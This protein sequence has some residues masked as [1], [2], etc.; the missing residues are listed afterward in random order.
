MKTW[1]L[2]SQNSYAAIYEPEKNFHSLKLV[3]RFEHPEG[4]LKEKELTTDSPGRLK[5]MSTTGKH[6][7][8]QQVSAREAQRRK[9]AH[10]L[11]DYLDRSFEKQQFTELI[12]VAPSQF[13]GELRNTLPKKFNSL[14]SKEINKDFPQWM[15]EAQIGKQFFKSI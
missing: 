10:K 1:I 13:L 9:F 4:R 6:R 11:C 12:L 2:I 8:G 14:I 3:Q 7:V 5:S 15:T